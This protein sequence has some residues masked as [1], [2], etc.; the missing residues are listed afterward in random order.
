MRPTFA[1]PKTDIIFKRIFGSESH[2]HLLIG[3]LN[4]LLELEEGD[5]IVDLS[6]LG[7]EQRIPLPEMKLSIVDVKCVDQ[8]DVR[9]VV[10]MQ[11]FNVQGFEERVIYNASKAFTLQ[12]RTSEDYDRLRGV[13]GVTICDFELWPGPSEKGGPAVP[14][15]SRW[16]MQEQHT[17]A[18]GLP[19][20]QYAFLEL[21]KYS[22]G[23]RPESLVDKWALFF[24]EAENLDVIPPELDEEPFREAFEIVRMAQLSEEDYEAYE[25]SKMAEQDARG[26][27]GLAKKEGRA[28]GRAEGRE[29]GRA[30]GRVEGREEGRVEGQ[31]LGKKQELRRNLRDLCKAL[32]VHW[33]EARWKEVETYSLDQL[34]ELWK[35]LLRD[36]C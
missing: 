19:Q 33:D 17:G 31:A 2:K 1:D 10:E 14:M 11:L 12:L 24:R 13:V 34:R 32:D 6:Y 23:N 29:E 7:A 35:T 27:L 21:P 30:E 4:T 20:V 22:S 36:R 9:Y 5:L 3:L 25:Q 18:L 28:E 16:H 15:L 8:R 26:A